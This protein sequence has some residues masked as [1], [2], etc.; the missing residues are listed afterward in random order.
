MQQRPKHPSVNSKSLPPSPFPD[1]FFML[2]VLT[3][4][5]RRRQQVTQKKKPSPG[6][7]MPGVLPRNYSKLKGLT[8]KRLS[9]GQETEGFLPS[10]I[11]SCE[12]FRRRH[13]ILETSPCFLTYGVCKS[14]FRKSLTRFAEVQI[15]IFPMKE[16]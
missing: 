2:N 8:Q 16:C 15:V 6:S 9:H 4:A 10:M 3:P 13:Y 1:P 12:C 11:Q 7:R 14:S 5:L